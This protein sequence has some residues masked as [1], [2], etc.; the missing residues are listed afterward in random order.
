M[1]VFIQ[2]VDSDGGGVELFRDRI[3]NFRAISY[4]ITPTNGYTLLHCVGLDI[5]S[6]MG[7]ILCVSK[8]SRGEETEELAII[9]LGIGHTSS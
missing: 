2:F 3:L 5:G 7:P 9:R 6:S 8:I 1:V 4:I